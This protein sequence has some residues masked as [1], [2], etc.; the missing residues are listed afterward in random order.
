MANNKNNRM[1]SPM[2]LAIDN[3]TQIGVRGLVD[4]RNAYAQ[5]MAWFKEKLYVG[6]ARDTLC[7][8]K[9]KDRSLPPPQMEFWP[10]KCAENEVSEFMRAQIVCYDPITNRWEKVYESPM[11][12][13]DGK[14]RMRDVSYRGME[15]HQGKNDLEPSLYVGSVS[16]TGARVLRTNDGINFET[17]TVLDGPSIRSLCSFKGKLYT[18]VIG[19]VG[20]HGNE[21]FHTTV[22][23]ADDPESGNWRDVS[24]DGFGDSC[25]VS[26]YEILGFN[27][28]LYV[29]TMNPTSGFQLWKSDVEGKVPYRWKKIIN[30]GAYRGF[31]NEFGISLC[32]FN[33]NLYVGTGIAGG[34][35]DRVNKVG[36]AAPELIRVCPD[37][38]WDL[39]VGSPRITP[40]GLKAPLSGIG[41]GF[42]NFF[43]GYLWRMCVHEGWLYT[44]TF[45]LSVFFTFKPIAST[46]INEKVKELLLD[47]LST[48]DIENF[49]NKFG[50]CHLWRT[51]DGRQFFPITR[52]GFG[53]KYNM[54]IRALVST[55]IGLMVGTA[56]PFGPLVG[57]KK[58]GKWTYEPNSRGGIEVWLGS[59]EVTER[60]EVIEK[61]D[62]HNTQYNRVLAV[63]IRQMEKL[64]YYL[65][66][67]DHYKDSG[68]HHIGYWKE[69]TSNINHACEVLVDKVMSL[70]PERR[71]LILDVAC[72]CGGTAKHLL[73]Y[74]KAADITGI[75]ESHWAIVKARQREKNIL[76]LAMDPANLE[77][78]DETFTNIV[79]FEGACYFNSRLDFLKEAARVL[80]PGGRLVLTDI[81]FSKD[82]ILAGQKWYRTNYVKNLNSYR[83]LLK[84]AGLD[85]DVELINLTEDTIRIYSKYFSEQIRAKYSSKEIHEGK[86]NAIMSIIS[87]TILYTR[88]YVL[89]AAT[90][91]N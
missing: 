40:D 6:T 87:R 32:E 64:F 46:K 80:K 10:V 54:G 61:N 48:E 56:N 88:E 8:M 67:K 76:F 45:N 26:I 71:G 1:I 78:P 17:T 15:V 13:V 19:K 68:F 75:D 66:L 55:P 30:A 28:F 25:N 9:R 49:A 11:V 24:S 33:G 47:I 79:S 65:L 72:G 35:Y 74:F 12:T 16:A 34:G 22:L 84:L 59:S 29:T 60:K 52:N 83:K 86:F 41:P 31:L 57:V 23:E 62:V 63:T 53:T 90:K 69:G 58:D 21:S 20:R 81:L 91:K 39:V 4:Q 50:G 89:V 82:A 73:K 3:F 5:S 14:T 37:D 70:I 2:G 42:N 43:N 36:P 77:F 51:K 38:T 7:L 18:S 27:G 44:G 85:I